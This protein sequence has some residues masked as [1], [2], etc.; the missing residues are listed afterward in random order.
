MAP[1]TTRVVP[2]T[3]F[4]L[5]SVTAPAAICPAQPSVIPATS[6]GVPRTT[7]A[8]PPGEETPFVDLNLFFPR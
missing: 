2:S 5:P 8:K 4:Q 1:F 6:G 3:E 7:M